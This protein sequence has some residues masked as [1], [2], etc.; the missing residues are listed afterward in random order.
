MENIFDLTDADAG[1]PSTSRSEGR[2]RETDGHK[3]KQ[4]QRQIDYGKNT[5]GYARYCELVKRATRKRGDAWTPDIN[6]GMSKR[7]FDGCVRKW[8]RMLHEYDPAIENNED[9]VAVP[10]DPHTRPE[11]TLK[12]GEY[13]PE[14]LALAARRRAEAKAVAEAAVREGRHIPVEKLAPLR[15]GTSNKAVN[16]SVALAA[17]L[18]THVDMSPGWSAITPTPR[19]AHRE[20]SSRFD[21]SARQIFPRTPAAGTKSTGDVDMMDCDVDKP[22]PRSIY[23]DWEGEDFAG[24]V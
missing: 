2:A 15:A 8:R 3:L 9:V 13:V 12:P 14:A 18:P 19:E 4:R 23:D 22:E 16:A 17:S 20:Q 11:G 5:L 24:V 7:A 6:A 1:A 21:V 10:V